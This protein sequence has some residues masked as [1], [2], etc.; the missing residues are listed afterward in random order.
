VIGMQSISTP[1]CASASLT[2]VA[3]HAGAPIVPPSPIPFAPVSENCD[4]V[5]R[6]RISIGGISDAVGTR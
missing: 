3:M 6:W 1:R 4:G 2:A 5:S